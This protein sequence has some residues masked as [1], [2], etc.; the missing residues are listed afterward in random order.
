MKKVILWGMG[1]RIEV[2][3][4]NSIRES[5]KISSCTLV[6]HITLKG[7]LLFKKERGKGH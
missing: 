3:Q 6:A 1:E 7:A 2:R 4:V 5:F